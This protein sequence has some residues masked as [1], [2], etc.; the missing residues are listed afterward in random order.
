[1]IRQVAAILLCL[2][3]LYIAGLWVYAAARTGFAFAWLFVLSAM[4]YLFLSAVNLAFAFAWSQLQQLLGAQFTPVFNLLL[5]AQPF[6]L[7]VGALAHTFIV[8]WLLRG[9]RGPNQAL[10]PTADRRV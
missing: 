2:G 3:Q 7:L 6:A 1:M 10:Q 9:V 8:T 4:L 5:V